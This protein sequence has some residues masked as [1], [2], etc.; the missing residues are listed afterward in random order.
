MLLAVDIHTT[1]L[2]CS[3]IVTGLTSIFECRICNFTILVE[4]NVVLDV[5]V[6]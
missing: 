3:Y 1:Q 6:C 2:V 5:P 4:A